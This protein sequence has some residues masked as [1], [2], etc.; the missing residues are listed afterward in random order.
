VYGF[1]AEVIVLESAQKFRVSL[2]NKTLTRVDK[3]ILL[4]SK[5]G[6][7]IRFPYSKKIAKRLFELRIPGEQSIRLFYTF[8][9]GTILIVSGYTKKSQKLDTDELYRALKILNQLD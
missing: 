8:T 4:L 6:S 1:F 9:K 3:Q 5:E 7:D 2:E